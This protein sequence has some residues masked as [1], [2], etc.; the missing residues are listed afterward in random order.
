MEKNEVLFIIILYANIILV[1][2]YITLKEQL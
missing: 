1:Y 2:F